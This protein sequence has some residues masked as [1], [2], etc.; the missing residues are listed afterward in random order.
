MHTSIYVASVELLVLVHYTLLHKHNSYG[1]IRVY[2]I[3][4]K[5]LPTSIAY[6]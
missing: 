3:W 5:V 4:F 2:D 1:V 6:K